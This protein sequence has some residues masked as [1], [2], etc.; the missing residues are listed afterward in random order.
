MAR[1]HA[2]ARAF[3]HAPDVTA[4]AAR[5]G[6]AVEE[7]AHAFFLVDTELQLGWIERGVERLPV[8][9]RMQ[10]WAL[11]ALRD[12]MLDVRRALAERALEEACEA[13]PEEA[14]ERFLDARRERRARLTALTRALAGE[15]SA[16]LSGLTL[17]VRQL[18]ALV[19]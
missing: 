13:S 12:D 15:D 2:Y 1:D 16:D 3:V 8:G 10:R 11:H 4:V 5:R 14:V 9:T 17:V 18:Q 19:E 7:V 6:R